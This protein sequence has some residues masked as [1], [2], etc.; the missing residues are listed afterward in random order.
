MKTNLIQSYLSNS[1]NLQQYNSDNAKKNFDVN[2]ELLN[3]TFIK[4]LPS[5]GHLVKNTIFDY[6]AEFFKDIK[7]KANAL[8]HSI[9]G[10]ANDNELGS[11]N[12]AG[13]K[14]GGLAIATYLLTRRQTPLTKAMEFVGLCSFFGAMEIWPKLALQLPAY[15]IHGFNIRQQ[16]RDNYNTKKPVFLDHQFIPWDLYSDEEINKIGDR[17]KVPKDIKNRRDFIQE[18]MRKIALQN[19]TLWMLTAGF[20]T[21][22]MSALICNALEHPIADYQ[23][24]KL[25]QKAADLLNKFNENAKKYDYTQNTTELEKILETN[26]G[27]NISKE[28]IDAIVSTLSQNLDK[29]TSQAIRKDITRIL[30]QDNGYEISTDVLEKISQAIRTDYSKVK[31]GIDDATLNKI[32]P[33]AKELIQELQKNGLLDETSAIKTGV[34]DFTQYIRVISNFGQTK[35]EQSDISQEQK[36]R[37]KFRASQQNISHNTAISKSLKSVPSTK[38]TEDTAKDLK[39]I[40]AELN[41]LKGHLAVLDEYAY[42]KAAMAPETGLANGWNDLISKDLLK[43]LGITNKEIKETRY[44]ERIVGN[45]IRDKIE[46]IAS[47]KDRYEAVIKTLTEKLS[48]IEE[49]TRFANIDINTKNADTDTTYKKC[50]DSAFEMISAPLQKLKMDSTLQRLFGYETN[51]KSS[52]RNIQ[53][54]YVMDRVTG[55]KGA[56]YRMMNTLDMYRRITE[57]EKSKGTPLEGLS[58]EVKEELVEMC[59]RLM[60]GGHS[61]DYAVKFY[62]KRNPD[63][64]PVTGKIDDS[65]LEIKNGKVVNKYVGHRDP[66]MLA[67]NGHDRDFY[68]RAMRLMYDGKLHSDTSQNLEGTLFYENFEAWRKNVLRMFGGDKYFVRPNFLVGGKETYSTAHERFLHLGNAL[69]DMFTK[70]FRSSYNS[71]RWL[72]FFATF[73]AGLLGVT[74]LSQFF[75]GHMHTDRY[76]AKQK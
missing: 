10:N 68:E 34:K 26:K 50:V 43:T 16:Y 64:N 60:I 66:K 41:K 4:P 48:K 76:E 9:Q 63:L 19:N 73:G 12:D 5:N 15:L 3:R 14:L 70:L 44:D 62:A 25:A 35:L 27:K 67:E 31:I 37:L 40:S 45:L 8:K 47:D 30:G 75:F 71:N 54:S 52:L 17:M 42:L 18:K 32:V 33:S 11:L 21:P 36:N 51:D 24:K 20:A 23:D 39:A 6:P 57:L 58:R 69:D 56:F 65:E 28:T 38:L 7:Y 61:S 1:T 49:R 55:V 22:I 53:L 29:V 46:D 74:V 13:M 72:K 59:K 2:K